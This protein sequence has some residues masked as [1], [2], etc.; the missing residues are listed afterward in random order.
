MDFNAVYHR[1]NDNY[2]YPL[3]ENRLIINIKTGLDVKYV[4]ICQGDPFKAGILGGGETWTGDMMNIPFKKRLKNQIW[5][6]T[7][8]EPDYK[9]L[10][11]YFE[12]QTDNEK[13]YYFEDGLV[14]EQQ[15]YL[16]GRSRQCFV[17]PWMNPCDIKK[18]PAWVNDTIW[19]Q[20]FPERFCNGDPSNDP[21]GVL[22]WRNKGSVTNQEFFGGDLQGIINKLDYLQ[23]LGVSGLYLTPINEAPSSHKYDTTDYTKIDP[24]FGTEE[25]MIKLVEEAHA[26]GIRIMLDGVFNH[27]GK[28]FEPWQDVEKRGPESPYFDWFMINEWPFDH[29]KGAAKCKQY[30]TFAFYDSMPKLNTNNPEVR[31][32]LIDVCETW[33]KKYNVDGIRLDVANEISHLFCKELR[34]RMKAINPD[35]YILGEIWH[36]AMPWL[37]G[38]EFDAVMNY[39][40]G[41]SIKDFWVDKSLTNEDFEYMINRCYTNYMQQTNDVLFNLLDSHDTKRLR[42]DVRNLDEYFQQIAVLFTM[43]GSPCIYYGTEIAMEGGHDPDCRRCMPWEEIEAGDYNDRIAII[44]QL[45]WLRKNEPLLR[46]RDFHFPNKIQ[47]PRVIEFMKVG[48]FDNYVEVIIN[49]AEEDIEVPREGEVLLSRHYI[50]STLL[51]NGILIRKVVNN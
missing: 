14:S 39:P 34:T 35:I 19:Y 15:M 51:K 38:D 30:Y 5:W 8:I 21:E 49:C 48:W 32:Y 26:R 6:T 24:H 13:W 41:G 18:T 16:E 36:D 4:N 43:P 1:G 12:L 3:D 45:L 17:F 40:L 9:R 20:I 11:Y 23:D 27:C 22:E 46:S 31:K 44:K 10:K 28:F 33:V 42:S 7:T 37:R 29:E 25:T 47:N 50:D 2:C